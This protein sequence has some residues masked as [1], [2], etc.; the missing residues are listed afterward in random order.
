M[1][2]LSG[3]VSALADISRLAGENV[4]PWLREY[5]GYRGTLVFGDEAGQTARLITLWDTR[6]DEQRARTSRGAMRDQ[7]ASTAGMEVV[8]FEV[9]DVLAHELVG[10]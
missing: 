9:F 1:S 3:P 10:D 7:L 8:A 6:E 2:T 5:E 4:G